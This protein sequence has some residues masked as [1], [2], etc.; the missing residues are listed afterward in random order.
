MAPYHNISDQKVKHQV[1]TDEIME[2][3]REEYL[4][5]KHHRNTEPQRDRVSKIAKSRTVDPSKPHLSHRF[6]QNASSTGGRSYRPESPKTE[7]ETLSKLDEV[8]SQMVDWMQKIDEKKIKLT[9]ATKELN[10]MSKDDGAQQPAPKTRE[11]EEEKDE[12]LEDLEQ[13]A[14]EE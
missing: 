14:K 5:E 1:E 7:L 10:E 8:K 4:E 3:V 12:W 11:A 2:A 9:Q 13:N 6:S